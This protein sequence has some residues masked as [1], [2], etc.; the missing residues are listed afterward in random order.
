MQNAGPFGPVFLFF[1]FSE[2]IRIYIC[3]GKLKR[4]GFM[5][6]VRKCLVKWLLLAASVIACGCTHT[7][8]SSFSIEASEAPEVY[9]VNRSLEDRTSTLRAY[10]SFKIDPKENLSANGS[11]T[12]WVQ[13]SILKWKSYDVSGEYRM[14]GFEFAGGLEWYHKAKYALCGFGIAYNDGIAHHLTLGFNFSHFEFGTFIGLFHQISRSKFRTSLFFGGYGSVYV[15][16]AF[17]AYS[18]SDYTP[19]VSS[20]GTSISVNDITTHYITLGY[21]ITKSFEVTAGAIGSNVGTQWHWAGSMG[22]GYYLF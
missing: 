12:D 22:V 11:Y 8:V 9:G 5:F 17:L 18:L 13:D 1:A 16:D 21:H 4:I 7:S 14:G 3:K 15:G 2:K 19:R 10:G 6:G 20:D